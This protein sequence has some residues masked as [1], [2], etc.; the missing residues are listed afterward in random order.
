MNII[1]VEVLCPSTSRKYD[2]KIPIKME[3][4]EIRKQM[5]EDIRI[6][7]GVP[8]LFADESSVRLFCADGCIPDTATPEEAGVRNG[9]RIMLI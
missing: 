4:C 1:A 7:E 2:Y 9:D 8:E 6:F 5:I 3:A